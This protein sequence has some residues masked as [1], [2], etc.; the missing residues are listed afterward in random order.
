MKHLIS[1]FIREFLQAIRSVRRRPRL[2][3]ITV[4]V[5]SLGIGMSTALFSITYG[6]LLKPL[7][8]QDQNRLLV[9]WKADREGTSHVGELSYAEFQDWQRQASSF[10]AMAAMPTTV[11]GYSVD[12][13]GYGEA[14]ELERTPVSAGFFDVLGVHPALGRTFMQS[15]DRLGAQ[16]TVVLSHALWKGKFHSDPS[17][18]GRSISLSGQGYTVIGVM[19]AGFEFPAGA[20]LWTPLGINRDWMNRGATFLEVIGRLRDGVSLQSAKTEIAAI[21]ARVAAEYPE[22]ADPGGQVPVL[23]TLPNYIF[24]MSKPAILLLWAGSLLLLA[25]ACFNVISLLVARTLLREREIAVRAALGATRRRLLRQFLAEGFVLSCAGVGGGWFAAEFLLELT[26]TVAPPGIPR[27]LSVHLNALSLLFACGVTIAIAIAFGAAP[28]LLLAKRDLCIALGENGGRTAGSRRGALLHRC[29]LTAEAVVTMVLLSSA[30]MVAHNFHDLERVPLGFA[31]QN[32]LTAQIKSNGMDPGTR[33][34]L[35]IQLLERVRSHPGVEAAGAVL[36]RPFE[37]ALGWD[38]QY[39]AMGQDTYDANHNPTANLE[40][41]TPGYFRAAGTPLLAG[42]DFG[43]DDTDSHQK[44]TIVSAS[45]A[46]RVF[47][48]VQGAIGKQLGL[49]RAA[50]PANQDWRTIIGVVADAQYRRLGIAQGDIFLP[51]LQTYIPVRYVVIR[52]ARDPASFAP[53]LRRDVKE[54]DDTLVV[55][56]VQ[57]LAELIGAARTG[58]RFSM[59]LFAV[60]GGFAGLLACVGVYGIVSDSVVQRRR[61]MAI[62]MALGAQRWNILSVA[63]HKEMRAVILGGVIGLFFSLGLARVYAHLLYGLHGTDYRSMATAFL[64]LSSVTLSSGLL[65]VL[66]VVKVPVAHL[67]LE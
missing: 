30:I 32:V 14:V 38:R 27:L 33:N 57:P 53:I 12:L 35:F 46:R 28:T 13:A 25:I 43:R 3:A 47:G 6:V 19:P 7:P 61:E 62:R 16:P 23:T 55:S 37:G 4:I 9:L 1:G 22:Y 58:P 60:F 40:A 21:M 20:Q 51:F 48:G 5:L 15:D 50:T 56:R 42:R 63:I 31:S 34:A 17:L 54:I 66:R 11:Y 52:T 64:I 59:L 26:R 2:F 10:S 18:L 49:A 29:L 41:I 36:L 44:V 8:F 45:L 65:P 24:G 67:L 39:R